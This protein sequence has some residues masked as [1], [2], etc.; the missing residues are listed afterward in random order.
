MK[1]LCIRS[2]SQAFAGAVIEPVLYHLNFLVSQL[3]LTGQV[4]ENHLGAATGIETYKLN[5]AVHISNPAIGLQVCG[6]QSGGFTK[7]CGLP[8]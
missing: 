7:Q 2:E 6:R 8:C 4:K 1:H 3:R 5:A